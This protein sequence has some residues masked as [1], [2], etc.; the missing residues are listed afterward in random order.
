M[1]PL[2]FHLRRLCWPR[3]HL[4]NLLGVRVD[5]VDHWASGKRDPPPCV[6]AWLTA[7]TV[8]E[9]DPGQPEGWTK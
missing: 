9:T 8:G 6:V 2:A 4:A 5:T 1:T 3:R 7:M